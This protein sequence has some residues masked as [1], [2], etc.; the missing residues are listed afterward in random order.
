MKSNIG[1][2]SIGEEAVD[3]IKSNLG[4]EQKLKGSCLMIQLISHRLT[5]P[6]LDWNNMQFHYRRQKRGEQS[7][8][9]ARFDGT[10]YYF[11]GFA[12]F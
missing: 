6:Q 8:K 11:A 3:W 2:K 7:Y 10:F 9:F 12:L 1:A 4:C 5:S